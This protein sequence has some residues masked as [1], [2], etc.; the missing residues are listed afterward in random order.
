MAFGAE[1][2]MHMNLRSWVYLVGLGLLGLGILL[3][4]TVVPEG[5]FRPAPAM[6][7]AAQETP[8]QPILLRQDAPQQPAVPLPA[9][10]QTMFQQDRPRQQEA[11]PPQ[12]MPA[13]PEEE[14]Q[15]PTGDIEHVSV[16]PATRKPGT[17][18]APD[19]KISTLNI[20][21]MPMQ[22]V[23]RLLSQGTGR[24]IVV[25][26]GA[27]K[28]RIN[29]YLEGVTIEEALRAICQT[30]ALW[31]RQDKTDAI[32]TIVT[33]EEY[34][35]G[36]QAFPQESVE[37]VTV[38]YPDVRAIGEAL[39]RLFSNR[40]V[41][42]APDEYRNDPI[43][44]V[45][46]ALERMDTLADRAQF[47]LTG[48]QGSGSSGSSRGSSRSRSSRGSSMYGGS[49]S[50]SGM[51]GN[52]YGRTGARG[53]GP[54]V[55]DVERKVT[56]EALAARLAEKAGDEK[57]ADKSGED[58]VL[59]PGVVYISAFK[60]TN[61]LMLRSSDPDSIKEV[62]QVIKRLDKPTPQVL[63]E[64]KV[65]DIT[66]D[67]NEACGVDW[68]FQAGDASGGRSTGINP[69]NFGTDF[70]TISK[71]NSSLVP[72]GTGMDPRTAVLQIVTDSVSA[73]IQMLQD[74]GR[75][76]TLATPNLC[77]AD[78]EASRV[79]VGTETTILKSVE[80]QQDTTGGNNPVVTRSVSP[81]TDRQNI[82]TTL[83]ITPRIHADRTTTIRLVQED[84]E[85]GIIQTIVFG[86][87][88]EGND[89]SFQS[90]D[91][92]TRSV[93]TTVVASDGKISAIGGLIR[94]KAYQRDVG[95]PGLM[96][97]P[98]VG[99]LFKTS[100]KEKERH[101]LLVLVRP[102]VLL[103][104]GE[105]ECVTQ[106]LMHRL[107]EHPSACGD[108]PAMRIGE[109]AFTIVNETLYQVPKQAF[110]GIKREASVWT[111]E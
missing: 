96:N 75:L 7:Q 82:G 83:L 84:S 53:E 28:T 2:G 110:D 42:N 89:Q 12:D 39:R 33:L 103:A 32:I 24:Q 26:Q 80:V 62:I 111:T 109:S 65:L 67:D 77:V 29:T 11:T 71:P 19:A 63:L 25:S 85:L 51:T 70:A 49:R 47:S 57:G 15:P 79:F 6:A 102:F 97:I 94:E 3:S 68:L 73:R 21:E 101:E 17:R 81:E 66:L 61:D 20:K 87:D 88:E 86:Q 8:P 16:H 91:V 38:L 105:A 45:E 5:S 18:L 95:V 34:Q 100:F 37:I 108:I 52:L 50:S 10:Q 23:A 90:Q 55:E 60:G 58:R 104:P 98:V 31:F 99:A 14:S 41:W 56:P 92:E 46:R 74:R 107:S 30:N 44:D 43:M 78:G 36:L 35:K 9:P 27:T 72:Q 13:E 106:D 22:Q 69:T 48:G 64:V 4:G 40:V 1:A 93:T 59:Q 54:T 76:V